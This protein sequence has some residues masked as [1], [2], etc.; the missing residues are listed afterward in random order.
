MARE[1]A[2]THLASHLLSYPVSG[3]I[4][5]ASKWEGITIK[6][7]VLQARLVSQCREPKSLLPI[8]IFHSCFG[9]AQVSARARAV[10]GWGCLRFGGLITGLGVSGPALRL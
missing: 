8:S 5:Y 4:F 3:L 2:D 1:R 9:G 7:C 6:I 10:R